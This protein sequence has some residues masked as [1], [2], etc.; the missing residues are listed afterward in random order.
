MINI[1]PVFREEGWHSMDLNADMLI[2]NVPKGQ[3][4]KVF[5]PKYRKFFGLIPGKVTKN[6]DRLFNRFVNYPN[7][8]KNNKSSGFFHIVDH[9]YSHLLHYLPNQMT[10]VYCHDLDAF[11]CILEPN[12]EK[13]P[14]WFQKISKHIFNGFLKAKIVFCNCEVTKKQILGLNHWKKD[15]IHVVP[16]GIC[17]EYSPN[18]EVE[19]GDYLLH[20]G[21]CIPR[22]RI[23]I[24]LKIF[25]RVLRRK[26]ELKLI[27]AGGTFSTNQRNLINELG[28][29]EKVE[30]RN[31]LSRIE[32]AK[33][34]RGAKCFIFPSESEGFGLPVIEAL[35]C[36][37]AVFA[38]N[39]PSIS[40]AAGNNAFLIETEDISLWEKSIINFLDEPKLLKQV[41]LDKYSWEKYSRTVFGIYKSL[42]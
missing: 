10:G 28:I 38:S 3:E 12:K 32:I 8:L 21:S 14:I 13:R 35:S 29:L 27:Q 36:G 9:S 20:V 34:Y 7:Y 25:A 41:C 24:L 5:S 31:G 16:P 4:I 1:I 17:E 30:Q 23:D 22:K 2:S 26:P 40:E 15:S 39:I 6:A 11:R 19:E 37:A 18:G 42:Y 33:L